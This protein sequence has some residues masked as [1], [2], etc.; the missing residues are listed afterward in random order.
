M[1][2]DSGLDKK[3]KWIAQVRPDKIDENILKIMKEAG[4]IRL[5]F[6]FE[7]GSQKVLD[8]L[9]KRTTVGQNY[10]A[11]RIS[12]SV[13]LPF[14]ANIIVGMP[15]E[16]TEDFKKTKRF[17]R[18]IKAHWIGFGEDTRKAVSGF[19]LRTRL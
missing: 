3:V 13:G 9:N 2:I 4:C 10:S 16:D 12:K 8:I 19:Y 5:E 1:M 14:Q 15:G 11:A 6:G 7:T 17:M 18:D